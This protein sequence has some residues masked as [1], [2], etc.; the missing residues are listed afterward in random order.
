M[1]TAL[2]QN[3]FNQGVAVS[4]EFF[5]R[6]KELRPLFILASLSSQAWYPMYTPSPSGYP[7]PQASSH[8]LARAVE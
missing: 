7:G 1:A 3:F 5:A 4:G 6:F 2:W 8:L